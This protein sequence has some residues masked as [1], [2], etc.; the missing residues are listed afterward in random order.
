MSKEFWKTIFKLGLKADMPFIIRRDVIFTNQ[1]AFF[2][3]VLL[4]VLS[5]IALMHGFFWRAFVPF[6]A[7]LLIPFVFLFQKNEQYRNAK[8]L[9]VFISFYTIPADCLLFGNQDFTYLYLFV[10]LILG[11]IFIH[12]STYQFI[13][14]AICLMVLVFLIL[15]EDIFPFFPIIKGQNS[16]VIAVSNLI[17]T[18]GLM[19]L[20]LRSFIGES[21][22]H[23]I[24]AAG[25]IESI[26]EKNQILEQQKNQIEEQS[27]A[28][29]LSNDHLHKEIKEKELM[30]VKLVTSNEELEQFA[31]AASHDLKE[32]LRTIGSFTQLIQKRVGAKM[33]ATSL[34]YFDFVIGG[35]QRMSKLLDDLLSLSRL[36][37]KVSYEEVD[38]LDVIEIVKFNLQNFLKERNGKLV[39]DPLPSIQGNR[40]Q[41]VQLFQNLISN[42]LKFN[43]SE[44]PSVSIQIEN[45]PSEYLFSFTDNGI[46]ISEDFKEKV[47]IAFQRLH[48]KV[49]FEGTGVGLA[50]CKKVVQNHR[51]RIWLESK[52]G[53]GTTFYFTIAR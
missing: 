18:F 5:S 11:L 43:K 14:F 28:I 44:I 41:L 45:R 31:Y 49:D 15:G 6:S 24:K 26:Q 42:A 38:L 8:Y 3:I 19:F 4:F 32:P 53:V 52:E 35:V 2:L 47:F 33:D 20:A 48:G 13:L 21:L 27:A 1:V 51:G 7:I 29:Q 40:L 12:D 10:S 25:L 50:I 39:V 30:E 34:E 17:F 46:G 23:E 22:K 9:L 16:W 36:N 37:K